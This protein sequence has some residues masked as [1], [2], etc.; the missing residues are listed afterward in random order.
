VASLQILCIDFTMKNSRK[1]YPLVENRLSIYGGIFK[2]EDKRT[3]NEAETA[4][5]RRTT[6]A[7][8]ILSAHF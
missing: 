8:N 1:S 7:C 3:K 6:L 4:M 5:K 2:N